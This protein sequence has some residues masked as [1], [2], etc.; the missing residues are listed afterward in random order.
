MVLYLGPQIWISPYHHIDLSPDQQKYLSFAWP[1]NGVLRYFTFVV[2][3]FGLSSACFCFTKLLGPLVKL[4]RSMGHN[5][6][7]FLTTGFI[8]SQRGRPPSQQVLFSEDSSGLLV[9]K[10]KPP[11]VP[12]TD[13][14][15][16]RI[17]YILS[18]NWHSLSVTFSLGV[19]VS[20][21][22]EEFKKHIKPFVSDF[23]C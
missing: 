6:L 9:E 14:V 21:L 16:S 17:W 1:F 3:S 2:L 12:M 10:K 22:R 7:F 20:T 8:V 4:W 13:S 15:L 23:C 11:W 19:S 5:Y 18:L